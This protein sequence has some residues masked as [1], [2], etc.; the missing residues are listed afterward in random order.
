MEPRIIERSAADNKYL[1]RDFHKTLELGIAYLGQ[2]FGEESVI[3]YLT[4]FTKQYYGP[5]IQSIKENGLSS[6]AKYFIE[7]YEAEEA[8]DALSICMSPEKLEVN[9]AYCP[10]IRHFATMGYTPSP[11]FPETTATVHRVLAEETGLSYQQLSYDVS[12]GKCSCVF[13]KE[14]AK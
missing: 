1:H 7:L 2:E 10:A 11:W 12:T 4:I 8:S 5:L 3:E 9:I 13:C 14:V 6:L